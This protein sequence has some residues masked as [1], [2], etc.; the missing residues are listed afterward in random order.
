MLE[1]LNFISILYGI[2]F[3]IYDDCIDNKEAY[4]FVYDKKI[5]LEIAIIL[6]SLYLIYY[7]N[8]FALLL[9]T[10]C[11]GML[12]SDSIIYGLKYKYPENN[13]TYAYDNPI[14]I[15]SVFIFIGISLYIHTFKLS[16]IDYVVNLYLIFII[17]VE[18]LYT[19]KTEKLNKI[20][21]ESGNIK[22]FTRIMS[23]MYGLMIYSIILLDKNLHKYLPI[24]YIA[25]GY[26]LTS[27]I[28][29]LY[30]KYYYNVSNDTNGEN[31]KKID[32][33]DMINKMFSK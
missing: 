9:I 2:L 12:I 11:I 15:I 27:V 5:I 20:E 16:N 29:M 14:Y 23:I 19:F 24:F 13:L 18:S 26:I 6:F 17:I 21:S 3:K 30:L 28:S 33:I 32:I 7:C 10:L 1:L 25:F 4:S 31:N 8:T 22:L